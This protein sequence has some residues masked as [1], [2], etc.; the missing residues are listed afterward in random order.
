MVSPVI[1]GIAGRKYRFSCQIC[2]CLDTQTAGDYD[3]ILR[4]LR[5]QSLQFLLCQCFI[6]QEVYLDTAGNCF[7]VFGSY[8]LKLIAIRLIDGFEFLKALVTGNDKQVI[9]IGQ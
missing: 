8:F 3:H 1:Q 6:T 5:N 2:H 4:P 7:S 9:F